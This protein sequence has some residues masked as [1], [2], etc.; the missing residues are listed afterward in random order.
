MFVD[1]MLAPKAFSP[2]LERKNRNAINEINLQ[3]VF[4]KLNI[5][6][7]LQNKKLLFQMGHFM[8]NFDYETVLNM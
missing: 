6:A 2:F 3:L 1:Y 7:D 5:F 8:K 4:K